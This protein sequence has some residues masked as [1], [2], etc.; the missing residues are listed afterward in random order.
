VAPFR[1]RG[2]GAV[3]QAGFETRSQSHGGDGGVDI[4]LYSLNHGDGDAPVSIV[5]CKQWMSWKVGV[6]K[7][8]SCAG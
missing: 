6:R 5:Q 7:C 8:A 4:W 2:R 1:G 3:Q